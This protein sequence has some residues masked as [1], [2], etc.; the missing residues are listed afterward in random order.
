MY[1]T[2]IYRLKVK[3]KVKYSSTLFLTS[4]I[5]GLGCQ[6]HAPAAL[7]RDGPGTNCIGVWV[8]L[9]AIWTAEE[10]LSLTEIRSSDRPAHS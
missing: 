6:H 3:V 10:N 9:R 8:G 7:T 1:L 4:A 5:D 2:G